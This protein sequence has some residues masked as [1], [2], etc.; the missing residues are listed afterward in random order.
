MSNVKCQ[1]LAKS[2]LINYLAFYLISSWKL[3]HKFWDISKN[4]ESSAIF[5]R[6][7]G[8]VLVGGGIISFPGPEFCTPA[9]LQEL[10]QDSATLTGWRW[11]KRSGEGKMITL[12]GPGIFS[13]TFRSFP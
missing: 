10:T 5:P 13:L 1:I 6:N 3:L 11:T 12:Y 7:S 4:G 8:I 9:L 2:S